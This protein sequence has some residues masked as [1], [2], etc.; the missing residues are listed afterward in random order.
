MGFITRH[1]QTTYRLCLVH[2]LPSTV[3]NKQCPRIRRLYRLRLVVNFFRDSPRK[4][5]SDRRLATPDWLLSDQFF[6]IFFGTKTGGNIIVIPSHM[7]Q[8][9]L[10]IISHTKILGIMSSGFQWFMCRVRLI[11]VSKIASPDMVPMK[12]VVRVK[13][14]S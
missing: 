7:K 10:G 8:I 11:F 5:C 2:F 14:R 1:H 3:D 9:Y 4:T 12:Y 6:P 13:W